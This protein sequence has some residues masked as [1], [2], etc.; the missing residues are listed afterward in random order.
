MGDPESLL[1]APEANSRS[2]ARDQAAGSLL[3]EVRG[4]KGSTRSRDA[5][6]IGD[7]HPHRVTSMHP[8]NSA[9]AGIGARSCL[10]H[11]EEAPTSANRPPLPIAVEVVGGPVGSSD[12]AYAHEKLAYL[13]RHSPRAMQWGRALLCLR[14]DGDG[15]STAAVDAVLVLEHDLVICGGELANTMRDA[16]DQ[17]SARLRRRVVGLRE[18]DSTTRARMSA[19]G[20]GVST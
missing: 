5:T 7:L 19:R 1:C 16:I 8:R 13:G 15:R 18:P 3:R 17:L 12:Q 4:A 11:H 6:G 2:A 9:G 20:A 10:L 14:V